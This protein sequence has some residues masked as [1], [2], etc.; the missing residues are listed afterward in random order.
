MCRAWHSITAPA[1]PHCSTLGPLP[2]FLLTKGKNARKFFAIE[3]EVFRDALTGKPRRLPR[4]AVALLALNA[5][6]CI[7]H[8]F[9]VW[10]GKP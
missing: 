8:F 3:E 7:L 2:D 4:A 1:L 6:L 9:C 5:Y 10:M